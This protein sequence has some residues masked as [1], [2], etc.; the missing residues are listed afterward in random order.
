[1]LSVL[2]KK[3]RHLLTM[4]PSSDLGDCGPNEIVASQ[5]CAPAGLV[6]VLGAF[7]VS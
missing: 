3:A 4:D 2:R 6:G 1:M 5:L 7:F